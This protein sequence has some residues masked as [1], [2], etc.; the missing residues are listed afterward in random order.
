MNFPELAAQNP[1]L[2]SDNTTTLPQRTEARRAG[3]SA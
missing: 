3:W 1:Q 2:Y